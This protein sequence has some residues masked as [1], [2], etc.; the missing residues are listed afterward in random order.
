[1]P[2]ANTNQVGGDF[3]WQLA[4]FDNPGLT[5]FYLTSERQKLDFLNITVQY[6]FFQRSTNNQIGDILK[7]LAP[8]LKAR[9]FYLWLKCSK[10]NIKLLYSIIVL[11]S[12]I[13]V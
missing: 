12:I 6:D 10:C 8:F 1:M 2:N 7:G 5:L 9:S 13:V 11:F 3:C 4:T